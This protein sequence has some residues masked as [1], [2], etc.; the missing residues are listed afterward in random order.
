[1]ASKKNGKVR[2]RYMVRRSSNACCEYIVLNLTLITED[3]ERA[4][5]SGGL[6]NLRLQRIMRLTREAFSQGALLGYE[7]LSILLLSSLATLKRDIIFLES[8]GTE[9]MLKGRRRKKSKAGSGFGASS[10]RP[11]GLPE[12]ARE[13]DEM[14]WQEEM[15]A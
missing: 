6:R 7:D 14:I 9:I 5:E 11:G 10:A 3:D 15:V 4:L 12:P 8:R 1:M 13:P 2:Y